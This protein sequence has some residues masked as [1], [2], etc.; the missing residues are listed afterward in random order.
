M[1]KAMAQ[2]PIDKIIDALLLA[3]NGIEPQEIGLM[4]ELK[5]VCRNNESIEIWTGDAT[6]LLYKVTVTKI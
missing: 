4:L 1:R 3:M 5:H 2:K 6:K